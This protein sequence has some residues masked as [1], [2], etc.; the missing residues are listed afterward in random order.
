MCNLTEVVIRADDTLDTLKEKVELATIMGTLQSTLVNFRYLRKMWADNCAEERLLGVSFTGI[1]DHPVMSGKKG[2]TTLAEWLKELREHAVAVNA[3]WAKKLDIP[4]SAAITTVK[5]SGTVSQ[6][7]DSSSGIHP[8]YSKYYART[9]RQDN[10]DPI[11]EFLIAQG[12]PSEPCAMKPETTTVFT[13]PVK[14]PKGAL[15]V[16][17]VGTIDQLELSKCYGDNWAEHTV[18]LTGY[19]TDD[20][21]FDTC[22]WIWK[23][24][25]SMIG[26]SFLPHDGGSY[27]QAPYQEIDADTHRALVRDM[28]DINWDELEKFESDDNTS[29]AKQAACVGDQCEL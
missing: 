18:S 29:G 4:A 25:D 3:K 15:T 17:D 21:W 28:P 16:S 11:T 7:V 22:S 23:N 10:K 20:T 27:K 24:W 1:C 8:R 6:L 9:I 13:F 5:P 26:M 2:M 14:S 12:V 19:Y